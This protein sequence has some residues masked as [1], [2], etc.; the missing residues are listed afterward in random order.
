M[1]GDLTPMTLQGLNAKL[2]TSHTAITNNF[3]TLVPSVATIEA[4]M[5]RMACPSQHPSVPQL[6]AITHPPAAAVPPMSPPP[7]SHRPI[8]PMPCANVDALYLISMP[9]SPS[10]ISSYALSSTTASE[11]TMAM[12]PS[13]TLSFTAPMLVPP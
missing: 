9:P 3:A 11:F 7:S 4:F 6:S 13:P 5:A 1:S 8:V 10:P 12:S 2:D